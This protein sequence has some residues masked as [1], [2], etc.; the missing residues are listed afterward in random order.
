MPSNVVDSSNMKLSYYVPR[1]NLD[2][3]IFKGPRHVYYDLYGNEF[4]YKSTEDQPIMVFDGVTYYY[5]EKK[6]VWKP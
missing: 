6:E 1:D 2:A 4:V 5:D 3:D